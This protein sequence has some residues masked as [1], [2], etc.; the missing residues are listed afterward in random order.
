MSEPCNASI[1]I[2]GAVERSRIKPLLE[3]IRLLEFGL[4]WNEPLRPTNPDQLLDTLTDGKL[5]L[6]T[7]E[8]NFSAL[9]RVEEVC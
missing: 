8:V 5:C 6:C 1:K 7:A 4:V 9:S 2:G 3:V